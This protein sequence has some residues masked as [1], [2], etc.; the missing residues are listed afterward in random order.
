MQTY[1]IPLWVLENLTNIPSQELQFVKS[2]SITE[3]LNSKEELQFSA[4]EHEWTGRQHGVW[5]KLITHKLI[6][7]VESFNQYIY[8]SQ[9][10]TEIQACMYIYIYIYSVTKL[11]ILWQR[12]S[13]YASLSLHNFNSPLHCFAAP[14]PGCHASKVPNSFAWWS[15]GWPQSLTWFVST[16]NQ[17]CMQSH[18]L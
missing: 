11:I 14:P 9:F 4:T 5:Y 1:I 2:Y 7:L 18:A 15:W 6:N 16:L 3:F 12:W 17:R 13:L 10:C 8:D